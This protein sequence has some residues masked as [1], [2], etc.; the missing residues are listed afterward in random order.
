MVHLTK[1]ILKYIG[2]NPERLRM[3]FMSSGDGMLYTEVVNSFVKKVKELG[4]LGKSEGIDE[5][6]LKSRFDSVKNLIPYIRLVERERIRVRF[7]TAEEYSKFYDSDEIN[8]LFD[9]TIGDKLTIS[10]IMTLLKEKPLTSGEISEVLKLNPSQISKHL[11]Y[12]AK[13]G[14]VRFDQKQK[15]YARVS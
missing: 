12:S 2:V 15:R 7:N 9:E 5:K 3:E 4:P 1:K 6:E 11:N 14:L 13:Q 8:K 10:Q